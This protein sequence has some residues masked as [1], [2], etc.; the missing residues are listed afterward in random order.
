MISKQSMIQKPTQ[1]PVFCDAMWVDMWP[2][3]TDSPAD[4]LYDGRSFVP[5]PGA[6]HHCPAWRRA[7]PAG[8]P[9]VFNTSQRL[10]GAL[11]IGMT[12]GHVELVKLGKSLEYYWHLNWVPPASRPD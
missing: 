7:T 1:T 3:E 12:D 8:A 9:H 4:D 10:P 2:L 6:L 5:R 11:N